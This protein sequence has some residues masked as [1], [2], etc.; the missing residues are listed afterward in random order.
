MGT[1]M[2]Q[3]SAFSEVGCR[4]YVYHDTV[5]ISLPIF[6]TMHWDISIQCSLV[7]QGGTVAQR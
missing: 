5:S 1:I 2:T 3:S 4:I 6:E 7:I